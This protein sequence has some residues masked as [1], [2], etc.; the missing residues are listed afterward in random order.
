MLFT[1]L[2][3]GLLLAPLAMCCSS[4]VG[5]A[6]LVSNGSA[7][8]NAYAGAS[9]NRDERRRIPIRVSADGSFFLRISRGPTLDSLT[10]E[11]A[12]SSV[13]LATP[14]EGV[15]NLGL[16]D[17]WTSLDAKNS[18]VTEGTPL[19]L[20]KTHVQELTSWIDPRLS[21]SSSS[22]SAVDIDGNTV[23]RSNTF[24]NHGLAETVVSDLPFRWVLAVTGEAACSASTD[25][26][27][28]ARSETALLP[29]QTQQIP[30][31]ICNA[32]ST[33]ACLGDFEPTAVVLR[34]VSPKHVRKLLIEGVDAPSKL[35]VESRTEDGRLVTIGSSPSLPDGDYFATDIH[36][37]E[38][39]DTVRIKG[40]L[41]FRKIW[42]LP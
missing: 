7:S 42:L 29:P 30:F 36:S 24:A 31:E 12:Y 27:V 3:L 9:E 35:T 20:F 2:Q 33:P 6:G 1:R 38:K 19:H 40:L 28:S 39:V 17:R 14:R 32:A 4:E 23:W 5:V 8:L 11:S 37:P 26:R 15:V 41:K 25:C 13:T 34:L 18:T 21:V 16:I 10:L 22:L